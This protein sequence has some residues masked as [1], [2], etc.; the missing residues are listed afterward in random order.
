MIYVTFN[1]YVRLLDDSELTDTNVDALITLQDA[2]NLE[3]ISFDATVNTNKTQITIDQPRHI[4][5]KDKF[6]S[7]SFRRQS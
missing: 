6:D 3:N 5:S 1:E 4:V 2:T 7:F